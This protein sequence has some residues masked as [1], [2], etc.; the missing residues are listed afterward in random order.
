[1]NGPYLVL[2]AEH[3]SADVQ[4]EHGDGIEDNSTG[5]VSNLRSHVNYHHI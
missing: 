1:M 2:P 3:N 4:H 5:I